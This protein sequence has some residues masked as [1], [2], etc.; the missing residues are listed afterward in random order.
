M[1]SINANFSNT[2]NTN[3]EYSYGMDKTGNKKTINLSSAEAK[4]ADGKTIYSDNE[5]LGKDQFLN[6]LMTQL[7]YQDPLNPMDDKQFISQMAQFS[8]LE[9]MQNMNTGMEDLIA[10]VQLT[11][12]NL[13]AKIED[14]VEELKELKDILAKGT[15]ETEETEE[16]GE[17]D[18]SESTEETEETSEV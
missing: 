1:S 2:R 18:E 9:Q 7:K 10:S 8:S 11:N 13:N 15:D 3:V 5:M 14:I 16:S 12:N 6:L 17:T 4:D